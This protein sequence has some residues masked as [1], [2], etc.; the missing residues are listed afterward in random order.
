ML[1]L[2]TIR[3]FSLVTD[4]GGSCVAHV[5]APFVGGQVSIP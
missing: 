2:L 4:R 5:F 1:N 3:A